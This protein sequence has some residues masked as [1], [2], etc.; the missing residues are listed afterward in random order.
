MIQFKDFCY[1][2]YFLMMDKELNLPV[3]SY[4]GICSRYRNERGYSCRMYAAGRNVNR[5]CVTVLV[6]EKLS[7]NT[8]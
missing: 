4:S 8:M 2:D 1:F 3:F 5:S 6:D 7:Q